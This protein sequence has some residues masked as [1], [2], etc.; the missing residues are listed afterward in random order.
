MRKCLLLKTEDKRKF[1]IWKKDLKHI[2]KF[3]DTVNLNIFE[4]EPTDKVVVLDPKKL[5]T[6]FCNP[7]YKYEPS[8][9]VLDKIFPKPKKERRTS[10][11][12]RDRKVMLEQANQIQTFIRESLL[13][14]DTVSLKMLKEKYKNCGITCLCN[15][16]SSARKQLVKEG[17]KISKVGAGKYVMS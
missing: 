17:K 3:A 5:A 6:E 7:N 16:L 14:G 8:V 4:V 10:R 1:L 15:H 13:N 9:T 2:L 12:K 11:P